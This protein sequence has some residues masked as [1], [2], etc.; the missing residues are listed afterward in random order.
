MPTGGST[1]QQAAGENPCTSMG[2]RIGRVEPHPRSG[3]RDPDV[4]RAPEVQHAIQDAGGDGDFGCLV[5]IG[6][7][8]QVVVDDALP[9]YDIDVG[10]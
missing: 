6:L 4:L 8:V 9:S 3:S 7:R 2:R 5:R 10:G 1:P